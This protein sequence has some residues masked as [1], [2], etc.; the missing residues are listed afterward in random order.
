[1]NIMCSF[2][3]SGYKPDM[4]DAD[5]SLGGL[6]FLARGVSNVE[7]DLSPTETKII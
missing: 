4:R 7:G 1:M 3:D 5:E 6:G 2:D